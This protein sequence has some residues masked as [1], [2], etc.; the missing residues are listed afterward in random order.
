MKKTRTSHSAHGEKL[1]FRREKQQ[2]AGTD[3]PQR[4]LKFYGKDRW[5]CFSPSLTLVTKLLVSP[6]VLLT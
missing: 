6:S 5:E 1:V 3:Q 2:D 4:N